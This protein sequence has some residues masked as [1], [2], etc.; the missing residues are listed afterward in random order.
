MPVWQNLGLPFQNKVVQKL[1][2]SKNVKTKK[3]TP[4]PIFLKE[5]HFQLIKI[6]FDKMKWSWKSEFSL[7]CHLRIP[8]LQI[9]ANFALNLIFFRQK[10]HPNLVHPKQ[11]F[12]N[13]SHASASSMLICKSFSALLQLNYRIQHYEGKKSFNAFWLTVKRSA[14]TVVKSTKQTSQ[15]TCNF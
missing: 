11:I 14:R 6:I 2:L 9:F 13:Q 10:N 4:N 7:V 12:H 1:K 15:L 5:H 8:Q 3:C